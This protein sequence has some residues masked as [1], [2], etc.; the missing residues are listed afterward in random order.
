MRKTIQVEEAKKEEAKK[1]NI[2][3]N[4]YSNI[5]SNTGDGYINA[6]IVSL[7]NNPLPISLLSS[8]P[9]LLSPLAQIYGSKLMERGSRKSIVVKFVT[10]QA[11]IWLPIALMGFLFYKGILLTYLPY[12]TI[13]LYSLLAFFGGLTGPAWFSWIGDLV[14]EKE[15][16][17]YFSKRNRIG[18]TVG[19]FGFLIGA[20]LLDF[21]QTKGIVTLGFSVLFGIAFT[22]RLIAVSFFKKIYEPKFK[23]EKNYYFTFWQFI[24][25][26][27][28]FF[29]FTIFHALFYFAMT[30]AGPFF[31]AYMLSELKFTYFTY[32]IVSISSTLSYLFFLPLVGKFSDKYGNKKLLLI[33]SV[34][35]AFYPFLWIFIKDPFTLIILPQL[36]VGIA[37]AGFSIGVTNFIYSTVTVQKRG[38]C[39]AYLNVTVGIGV[40]LGSLLGGAIIKYWHP[41]SLSPFIFAFIV[42]AILRLAVTITFIQ[43]I[44]EPMKVNEFKFSLSKLNIFKLITGEGKGLRENIQQSLLMTHI[45][46][47]RDNGLR[48]ESD[49]KKRE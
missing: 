45:L 8:M 33:S 37:T 42:S 15:R 34:L 47:N 19:L 6:F 11:T 35:F 44:K 24:N 28:N 40:F 13:L 9:G 1:F 26:H 27:G 43:Q 36:I 4:V 21:F 29:R 14:E 23:L 2:K 5:S 31:T 30:I 32:M 20:L 22:C 38:I 49:F 7:T 18:G 39:V 3:E 48:K 12:I 25:R 10:L 16:G 41:S 17:K 46:S